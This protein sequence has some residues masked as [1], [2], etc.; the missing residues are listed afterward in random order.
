MPSTSKK[1][2]KYMTANCKSD[3]F[4]KKTGWNTEIRFEKTLDDIL[5]YWRERV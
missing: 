2:A 1:Q 4:R 5:Q 3:K